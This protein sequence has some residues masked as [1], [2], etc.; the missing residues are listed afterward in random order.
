MLPEDENNKGNW[1]TD[2][3]VTIYNYGGGRAAG[4]GPDYTR[5]CD[6]NIMETNVSAQTIAVRSS[7]GPPTPRQARFGSEPFAVLS[8]PDFCI[9]R[10]CD[11]IWASPLQCGIVNQ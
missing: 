5:P 9:D 3:G 7:P 1:D 4:A 10:L 8:S 6:V 11:G 2:S